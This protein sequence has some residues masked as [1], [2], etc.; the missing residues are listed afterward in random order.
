MVASR[1]GSAES[2]TGALVDTTAAPTHESLPG[3]GAAPDDGAPTA[4]A[5]SSSDDGPPSESASSGFGRAGASARQ[6]LANVFGWIWGLFQAVPT[7]ILAFL[8]L[9][10]FVFFPWL[11]PWEPPVERRISIN[12]LALAERDKDLGDG[13]LVN[14]VY[15]VVEA[16]GYDGDPVSV[17][18]LLYDVQTRQRL[19]EMQVPRRWGVIDFSTRSDAVMG[20]I[21]VPPP[22]NHPG[23]VFVRIFLHPNS[24][25][26]NT[27]AI[28]DAA[29]TAAFDPIDATNP[30]CP[31]A[32]PAV[33]PLR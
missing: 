15:F 20:E 4:T 11:R 25:N 21:E 26:A 33:P 23:C 24:P 7:A 16:Y 28:L 1:D 27:A 18:W 2:S 5:G 8:S 12:E 9:W 31:D 17:D 10:I 3:P 32:T 19:A 22:E 29:D 14:A 6:A 30:Q 13:R